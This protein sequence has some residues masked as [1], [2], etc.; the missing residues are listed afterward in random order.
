MAEPCLLCGG[1][2][3]PVLTH[4]PD[5]RFA[6]PGEWTILRCGTCGLEQTTPL[7]TGPQLKTLYETYYNYGGESGTAYTGW[8]EK[9]LMSPAYRL[10]LKIDGDVSFHTQAGS[11][12]LLDVGCNEGRGL[13]IYRA[14]GFKPEGLELNSRAA[15]VARRRGFM[16]Y[17]SDIEALRPSLP[18][19]RVVL[20]NVL[21]HALDPKKMLAAIHRVLEPGGEVWISLPNRRSWLRQ[22]FG[23]NWINWH[24]PFHIVHFDAATLGRALRESGFTVVEEKQVT[25]ALWVALSAIAALFPGKPKMQ[26]QPLLV[27]ALMGIARG[28]L[29]P[30]LWAMNRAG[31]G[32]C[33]VVK[34]RKEA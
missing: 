3:Q 10:F 9:L 1:A 24:L 34:A 7:P 18:F 5:T 20:S 22:F 27:V 4:V 23:R 6:S 21:E 16:V 17:E 14:N 32:D 30:L 11:G 12:R 31:R 19:D 28:L 13:V 2:T 29:F 25:P 15:E 26:R 8:R 33:L